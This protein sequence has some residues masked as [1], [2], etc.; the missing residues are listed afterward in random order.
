[1]ALTLNHILSHSQGVL[2]VLI[3]TLYHPDMGIL[4]TLAF[5]Q[6]P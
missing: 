5:K 6:K 3:I 1:M 4:P 2:G